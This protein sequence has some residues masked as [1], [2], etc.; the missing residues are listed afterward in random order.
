MCFLASVKYHEL[1]SGTKVLYNFPCLG[2]VFSPFIVHQLKWF[3]TKQVRPENDFQMTGKTSS[4]CVQ[5]SFTLY[6]S[7][8]WTF[9]V[10]REGYGEDLCTTVCPSEPCETV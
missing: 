5:L 2:G 8:L 3:P 1:P 9:M 4:S 10:L 7:P 6:S